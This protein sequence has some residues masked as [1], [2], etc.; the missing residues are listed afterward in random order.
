[1]VARANQTDKFGETDERQFA[2]H[3]FGIFVSPYVWDYVCHFPNH[4]QE[5]LRH[6]PEVFPRSFAIYLF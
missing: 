1:M 2:G 5:I 3:L 6:A 4:L